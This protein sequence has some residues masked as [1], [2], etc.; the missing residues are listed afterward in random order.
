MSAENSCKSALTWLCNTRAVMHRA[1]AITRAKADTKL[2][3]ECITIA[4][5][6][7]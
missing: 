4:H 6:S 1:K 3:Y 5:L 7:P 2:T